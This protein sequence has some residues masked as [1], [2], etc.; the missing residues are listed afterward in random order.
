MDAIIVTATRTEKRDVDVPASTEVVTAEDIEKT[1]ATNALEALKNVNGFSYKS[2]GPLGA[3]MGTM[4]NEATIRGIDNGTLVLVNGN[5]VSWRGKY[6]LQEIPA[7]SIERIEIVKGGGSVLYGSE[8]MAGV[9]NIITKKEAQSSATVG[10][11]NYGQQKYHFNYGAEGFNIA[12]DYDKW[13]K[14]VDVSD[15]EIQ[16]SS[17]D[18][19][20]VGEYVTRFS[21]V[22][23]DSVLMTYKASDHFD[24]LYGHYRTR[25]RYMKDINSLNAAYKGKAREGERFQYRDYTTER[26]SGQINYHDDLWK[27]SLYFN[28]GTVESEGE[29]YYSNYLSK[30]PSIYNTREKNTT[31]GFDGQRTWKLGEK[32]N[33]VAGISGQRE[34]YKSLLTVSTKEAK[35]YLRNNWGAFVQWE[36]KFDDRNTMIL[37]GRETWTTAA[38]RGM[39][40]NNF[41]GAGQFI[42]K[43]GKDDNIYVNVNQSFIM[44]TF[45]QMYTQNDNAIPNPDLKPQKGVNYELGWKKQTSG[46]LWKVAVFHSDIS[47]NISATWDKKRTEYQYKNEDFRNTGIELSGSIEGKNGFSYDF[48]LTWQDP[49]AKSTAKPYWDRKYGKLQLTGGVSYKRDKWRSAITASYLADRVNTPSAEHSYR[50]KPYLLTSLTIGYAPNKWGEIAL[51]I[52]NL[53]NRRDNV[54]HSSSP[55]YTPGTN[56]MLSYTQKF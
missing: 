11:G 23:N 33:L 24:F 54:N 34:A 39:N 50:V 28:T 35:D 13:K 4:I 41:S 43:L 27:A 18:D 49:K 19:T 15:G 42:H 8:A 53:L 2:F 37:G 31:Y 21:D 22:K 47:D 55:Y 52:E 48:G 36:Q 30:T 6:N 10:F 38:E 25:S 20:V 9:I 16:K 40:Y 51:A 17:K 3:S 7:D 32:A 29:T 14:A 56:F 45:A 46:H 26:D 12:Y 5:P 44:P 1:G